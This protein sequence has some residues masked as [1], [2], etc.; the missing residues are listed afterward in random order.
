V[1]KRLVVEDQAIQ[2]LAQHH[3]RWVDQF[4]FHG[5]RVQLPA[6]LFDFFIQGQ[7]CHDGAS[8][9]AG[10]DSGPFVDESNINAFK[11]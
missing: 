5:H 7:G 11:P 8:F 6:E 9:A 10:N 1:G 4:F 3:K 2:L